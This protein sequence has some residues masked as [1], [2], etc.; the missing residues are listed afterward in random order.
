M[1]I[2]GLSFDYHDASA[3]LIKDGVV[4]AAAQEERF[5]RVKNDSSFPELA[6]S[7]CLEEAG[8]TIKDVD[9]A[10]FYEKTF[11]R[12]DRIL[13]ASLLRFPTSKDYIASTLNSWIANGKLYTKQRISKTTGISRSKIH[14]VKH[15][16]SHAATA[17]FC[18]PFEEATIITI[19]GVG[20]YETCTIS[21]GQK[22][23][24]KNLASMS[25]PHSLGLFYSAFT[26]FL[27]FKVNEDEYKVMGMAGYGKPVYYDKI[28]GL[29]ELRNDGTFS[30]SQ[31][32]FDFLCP[33][34]IP[35]TDALVEAFGQ[36]REPESPFIITG[37]DDDPAIIKNRYYADL[38]ASVQKCAEEVILHM[39]TKA[40]E[41]TGVRD[42]CMAGGVALNSLANGRIKRELGCRLYV[43]P[44]A[45]DAGSAIGA[46]LMHHHSIEKNAKRI[47]MVNPYLGKAYQ[48]SEILEAIE[49]GFVKKYRLFQ[50]NE[51]LVD[52]VAKL[53]RGGAIIGWLQGR[54]EWG[55]RALGC[56]S[57]LADPTNPNMQQIVNEKIKFREPFRPFAPAAIE[58]RAAD[59]FDIG[60]INFETDPEYFMLAIANV[61]E[62]KRDSIPAVTHV[63]GTARV[64]LVNRKTNEIFYDLIRKFGEYSGV[65]VLLNTSF[66]LRGEPI[67][68]TPQNALRTFEWSDMDYLVMGRY[69][70]EKEK[71]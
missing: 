35:Y 9:H 16:E 46:A 15:H 30:L 36:P 2:L 66:N 24:I 13:Q 58:E 62:D 49:Q 41:K 38:A 64:Q 23:S 42:V 12:F 33:V 21:Y 11:L 43:H 56:R 32:Y 45:G 34:S 70:I 17:F 29:F 39:V 52:E 67:V 65:P 14:S 1:Y 26:A 54:F 69:L 18:S 50:D 28:M 48:D 6:I 27:G 19:D 7:F 31:K 4:V 60:N 57:I 20:E 40:V 3:A 63:D 53:L 47:P 51:S 68:T 71:F 5:S 25:L 61:H 37:P 8:I 22:N 59:Y 44:A 10:V 55:P